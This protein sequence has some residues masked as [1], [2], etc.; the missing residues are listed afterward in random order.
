MFWFGLVLHLLRLLTGQKRRALGSN[1]LDQS[2]HVIIWA[3]QKL[4]Q[5]SQSL[6]RIFSRIFARLHAF[7]RAWHEL[8]VFPSS[9]SVIGQVSDHIGV[10]FFQN[11]KMRAKNT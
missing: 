1:E 9:S 4:K 2:R 6:T 10:F 5:I 7:L 3:N 11:G 8:H